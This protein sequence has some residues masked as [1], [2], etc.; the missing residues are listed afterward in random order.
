MTFFCHSA[1][2]DPVPRCC[3][4]ERG[5]ACRDEDGEG[6]GC[7]DSCTFCDTGCA[8]APLV[9]F[10][11]VLDDDGCCLYV[12]PPP[13]ESPLHPS[14]MP[15]GWPRPTLGGF[16]HPYIAEKDDLG[17]VEAQRRMLCIIDRRCQVCGE[18]LGE[19]SVGCWRP[20]DPIIVDGAAVCL[21]CWPVALQ[22]CPH[23]AKLHHAGLLV[24]ASVRSSAWEETRAPLHAQVAGMSTG[25]VVPLS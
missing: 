3:T 13:E 25:Y 21:R 19:W 9:E 7:P 5:T 24:M 10:G 15:I 22:R 2:M 20:K 6:A 8:H 1:V 4:C 18:K 14:Q 12:D 23:L 11:E 16:P 17:R